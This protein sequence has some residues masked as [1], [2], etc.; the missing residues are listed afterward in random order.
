VQKVEEKEK[1]K[2][3]RKYAR[4]NTKCPVKKLKCMTPV[5]KLVERKQV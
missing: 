2:K 1:D 4:G 3:L 5:Q